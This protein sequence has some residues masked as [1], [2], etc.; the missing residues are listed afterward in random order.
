MAAHGA[1]RLL[2]MAANVFSIVSIEFLAAAQGCDFHAPLLSSP[3]LEAARALLRARVPHLDD[4]RYIQPDILQA[5]AL[6]R[7]G[8]V[9]RASGVALPGLASPSPPLRAEKDLGCGG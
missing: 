7:S 4:D 5:T 8:E 9:A 3:P 6:V 2:P 1:T